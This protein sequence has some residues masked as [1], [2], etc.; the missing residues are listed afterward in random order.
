M[1]TG[2]R[3]A[4]ISLPRLKI[5]GVRIHHLAGKV[6]ERFGWSLNWADTRT[7]TLVE[8]TTD[9]GL[10]GWGDGSFGGER[11]LRHPELAIGRS[12]F[13]VEAI[14]DGLRPPAAAQHDRGEPSSAGL[15][16]ALWDICGQALGKP[17]WA[18]LGHRQAERVRPYCTCMYRKDWP[19]FAAGLAEE[20][21]G[22]KSQGFRILKM[23]TGYGP[24]LDVEIVR[25]VREALGDDIGLAVDS[26]CAY[27]DGS[28][29]ALG[30]RL[31]RFNLL[32]W[33][34]PIWADDLNGY[35]RLR[36][37][38]RIPLASGE[39]MSL[40]WLLR[41]YIQPKRV[42]IVQPDLDTVGLTG[43]RRISCLCAL[44]G[45]RLVPHNW[46]T[47]IRTAAELHWMSCFPAMDRWPPTFEFDQT[48]SPFRQAVIRQTIEMDPADG[49]IAVPAGP[50]LGV[51]V[52]REAVDEFCREL[53][54]V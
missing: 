51:D 21:L 5:T 8:V 10:T 32:W 3:E 54:E 35:D 26:N 13:E 52:V 37:M 16:V 25:A 29:L 49:C 31:E 53:I 41:N 30:K 34:E 45:L 22:W 14:F 19:D 36:R 17:I 39:T 44:N 18:L 6:R 4:G 20:A 2:L 15:D 43:G 9:A 28:A 50:G 38:L 48:E 27:D 46:G 12:P 47:H 33:E 40:D 23:K 7:A 24:D 42:P 1:L 11:L